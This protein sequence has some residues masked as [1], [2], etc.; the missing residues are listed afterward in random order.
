MVRIAVNG[1]KGRVGQSILAVLERFPNAQLSA[2]YVGSDC[3][4]LNKAVGANSSIFYTDSSQM[5][6]KDFDVLID[7]SVV[8]AVLK[9]VQVC[10]Q[11]QKPMVIGVTGFSEQQRAVIEKAARDIPVLFAP[12]MSLGINLC[13]RLLKQLSKTLLG[14][15]QTNVYAEIDI[16]DNHH[17]HKVDSPSGTALKMSEIINQQGQNKKKVVSNNK[18]IPVPRD[19]NTIAIHSMRAGDTVGEHTVSYTLAGERIEITHRAFTREA[20]ANGAICAA[21]TMHEHKAG[22]YDMQ[23]VVD[24]NLA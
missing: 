24:A 14:L 8:P 17:H 5:D 6:V 9:S 22:L 4:D 13:L 10:Q 20:Y 1:A 12:N 15:E 21:L 19:H 23:T 2:A 11:G 3:H 16:L 7:F 18:D